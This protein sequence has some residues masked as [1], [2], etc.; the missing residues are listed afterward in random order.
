M[1]CCLLVYREAIV[2]PG[3]GVE[4]AEAPEG[5]GIDEEEEEKKAAMLVGCRYKEPLQRA[6]VSNDD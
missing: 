6:R 5:R 4:R 1:T 3:A 2:V